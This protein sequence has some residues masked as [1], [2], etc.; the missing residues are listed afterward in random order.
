MSATTPSRSS[1]GPGS[2]AR[3]RIGIGVIGFGWLGQAHS[4]SLLRIPTLF[5]DREYDPV[6]IAAADTVPERVAQAVRSFGFPRG[7]VDWR[8]VIDDPAIDAVFIAAPNMLHLEL[9]QA[10]AQAGKAVFCE[11][12]VGGTPEQ[13]LAAAVA[14][15]DAGVI[16]GV[17]YNYRWAPLVQYARELIAGGELGQITNY[18]GRFFSMYGAD[19]L[20]V[21]SWRFQLDQAGYGVTSDLLSHTVDLAHMLLGPIESVVASTET[22][23]RSRPEPASAGSHYGRGR[24]DDPRTPVTNEDYVGMLVRFASGARGTFEAS[25][26]T[27]GPESENAF[28]VYGTE[29]AVGWNLERLN[30][31]RLYRR[32]EDRGSGY[33]TVLGGD[34]FGHHGTFVPGSGNPIGFEDLVTIEDHEFCRAVARGEPF[35]P[36]FQ[37]ALD[38]A[39][40]QAALLRSVQTGRWEPV[41][42]LDQTPREAT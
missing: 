42:A 25:R 3:R 9:V 1:A 26:T 35:E 17:G 8:A 38:W 36:S 14:A 5:A 31:L 2:A 12:P 13:V 29:G 6:L 10:A 27:V 28:D 37:Q 23:I 32:T 30:E 33:I 16:S 19:P 34:R 39:S 41:T 4:R 11:K 18:R 22:F 40:V 21:N 24:P 15:R 20:G 7:S